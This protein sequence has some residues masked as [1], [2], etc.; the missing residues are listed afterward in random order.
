MSFWDPLGKMYFKCISKMYFK[1]HVRNLEDQMKVSLGF[2]PPLDYTPTAAKIEI[3]CVKLWMILHVELQ[4]A[5]GLPLQVNYTWNNV[6]FKATM[7]KN[8]QQ[9]FEYVPYK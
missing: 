3:F 8:W 5:K 1:N 9:I 6:N 2:S 7:L 4:E